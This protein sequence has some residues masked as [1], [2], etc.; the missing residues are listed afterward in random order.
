MLR[1]LL[2]L[3]TAAW[4]AMQP[5]MAQEPVEIKLATLAPEGSAWYKALARLSEEW[6]K[7]SAGKVKLKIYPGGVA[8]NETVMLRKMRIGQLH[9]G[10]VTNLGLTEIDPSSQVLNIPMLVRDYPELDFLMSHLRGDFEKRLEENGY[11]VLGWSEAGWAYMF[12]KTPMTNP[13][14]RG[15]LKPFVWEGDPAAVAMYKAAGLNPVVL[16]A[17]DVLPSLQ[18]GMIDSFPTTPL[19]A[20]ALQWFGVAP[21]MLDVPWAPLLGATIIRKEVWETVPAELRPALLAASRR[22]SDEIQAQI[23]SQDKKAIEV[24]KSYGLTVH[25][26]DPATYKRWEA[27]AA[28]ARTSARGTFVTAELYDRVLALIAQ[29]RAANP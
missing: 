19:A 23:R 3:L 9:A 28:A 16:S 1:V 11:V 14:E 5:A 22:N 15:K 10:A 26:V 21:N 18:S 13:D 12:T 4:L 25:T 24:M 29:H 7:L 17:T 8:G 2:T 20:L 6:T 27:V